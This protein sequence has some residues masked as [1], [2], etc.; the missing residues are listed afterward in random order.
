M[1]VCLLRIVWTTVAYNVSPSFDAVVLSYP[2]SWL[3]ASAAFLLYH[4]LGH[5][6]PKADLQAQA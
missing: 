1:G 2:V 6:L 5:W 4:K 3:C